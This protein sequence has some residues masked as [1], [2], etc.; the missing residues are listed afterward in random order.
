MT[1]E[2]FNEVVII[3]GLP[4]VAIKQDGFF[5]NPGYEL[6]FGTSFINVLQKKYFK[7]IN[8]SS[9]ATY[10]FEI[11]NC[12]KLMFIPAVGHLKPRAIKEIIAT[13]LSKEPINIIKVRKYFNMCK[14][15][16]NSLHSRSSWNVPF[17]KL[18]I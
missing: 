15:N 1:T 2:V 8:H 13:V 9:T 4:T 7:I 14:L 11:A 10:K 17:I 12:D 6:D 3:E 16:R 5:T 18:N